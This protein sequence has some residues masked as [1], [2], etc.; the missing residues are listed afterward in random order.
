MD[1]PV[2]KR[3]NEPT[4]F[5]SPARDYFDGGIDLNRHLIRDRT[6]TFV[7]RVSGDSMAGTG[8]ADGDEI[9]V[10]RA[11]APRDGSVVVVVVE[12]ELLIRRLV[13][14][15][16]VTSLT[17]QPAHAPSPASAE[18]LALTGEVSVWGV[19]TR[20]LHHV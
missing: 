3:P 6:S 8:I 5:A 15:D 18:V 4:G 16:G 9:I 13:K 12:G 17:T 19:V 2:P 20:C 1:L 7:M 10:D 14:H 11:L